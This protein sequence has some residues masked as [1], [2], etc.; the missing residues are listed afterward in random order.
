MEESEL[1]PVQRFCLHH[2]VEI[3]F[4][5]SLEQYGLVEITTVEE[6][7]Y[8]TG[9]QLAEAERF[10]RLHYDLEI[11][12]AGIEAIGHLLNKMSQIQDQ[13]RMLRNRLG[14]YEDKSSND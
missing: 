12:F 5:Q 10:I 11:N 13:N 3:S 4:I 2:Q 8:F 14:L 6:Q 1:I 9:H 7:A